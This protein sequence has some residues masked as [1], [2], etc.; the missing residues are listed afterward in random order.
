MSAFTCTSCGVTQTYEEGQGSFCRLCGS[1]EFEAWQLGHPIP[2]VRFARRRRG[3]W[4]RIPD[5][6]RGK[7]PHRR[8]MRKR[9]LRERRECSR[10]ELRAPTVEEFA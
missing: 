7:V 6:W 5:E 10:Q 1:L 3:Q 2:G 4:V 9:K 8:T